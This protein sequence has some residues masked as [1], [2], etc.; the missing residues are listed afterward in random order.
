MF[1]SLTE[2]IV[3]VLMQ[4]QILP[5]SIITHS[6]ACPTAFEMGLNIIY[7]LHEGLL[8]TGPLRLPRVPAW[9]VRLSV[10][11]SDE[12]TGGDPHQ[13]PVELNAPSGSES[14]CKPPVKYDSHSAW[15][16]PIGFISYPEILQISCRMMY[17][18]FFS[19]DITEVKVT[20]E[21]YVLNSLSGVRKLRLQDNVS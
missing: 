8:C 5:Q 9:A 11:G 20:I 13:P 3:S 15:F 18:L 1:Y 19:V 21:S 4:Q 10:Q 2:Y 17:L 14:A 16:L 7:I 12:Q 6:W